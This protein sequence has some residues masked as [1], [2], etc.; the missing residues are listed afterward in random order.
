[1]SAQNF[2]PV[3]WNQL[4]NTEAVNSGELLCCGFCQS[5]LFVVANN[6]NGLETEQ[7]L[8]LDDQWHREGVYPLS[9]S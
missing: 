7:I 4:N 6:G 9:W 1:M 8:E 5:K 3:C 2:C